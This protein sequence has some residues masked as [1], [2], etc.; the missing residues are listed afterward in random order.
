MTLLCQVIKPKNNP[1]L[2]LP[3][4]LVNHI[5]Q[6]THRTLILLLPLNT[7]PTPILTRKNMSKVA[8]SK[9]KEKP[10][11]SPKTQ[12][13]GIFYRGKIIVISSIIIAEIKVTPTHIMGWFE[14]ELM[15]AW[16]YL[17]L[18]DPTWFN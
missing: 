9:G 11:E 14:E 17:P 1:H 5:P 12:E 6:K 13:W 3:S 2:P 4:R 8:S 15:K 16:S 10:M 7:H 18:S